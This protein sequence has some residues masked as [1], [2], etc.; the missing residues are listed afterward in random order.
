MAPYFQFA[1]CYLP[2]DVIESTWTNIVIQMEG[3]EFA[4]SLEAKRISRCCLKVVVVVEY[5]IL[6]I[7]LYQ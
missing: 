5:V 1:D 4:A 6:F 3:R 7:L 2:N